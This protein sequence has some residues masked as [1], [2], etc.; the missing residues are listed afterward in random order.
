MRST[1]LWQ[2]VNMRCLRPHHSPLRRPS[3]RGFTLVEVM[4]VA[5]ILAIL[6]ALAGPNFNR[7]IQQTEVNSARD[8]FEASI[9]FARTEAVRTGTPTVI[10]PL[11]PGAAS[12]WDCGWAVTTGVPPAAIVLRQV[13][14][15]AGVGM[16]FPGALATY[17]VGTRGNLPAARFEFKG[18][19]GTEPAKVGKR[20]CISSGGR[21]R[22]LDELGACP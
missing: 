15:G 4:V 2:T 11:C 1:Q 8:A 20:L 17:N 10:R 9:Y 3:D 16:A 22:K 7:L 14:L 21:V 12:P 18:S 19:K 5:A 13:E 6:A